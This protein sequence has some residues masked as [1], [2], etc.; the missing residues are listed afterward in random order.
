M[1]IL[2]TGA[3]GFI[4]TELMKYFESR[5]HEIFG[6]SRT[7]NKNKIKKMELN[8]KI[9]LDNYFKK[10]KF[11]IVI[12]LSSTLKNDN[13]I[14]IF[15]ENSIPLITLLECCRLNKIK[16][17]I[18]AS[19]HMV[20]GNTNYV[21]IDENHPKNPKMNYGMMK[22]INENICK[23]YS[24]NYEL[25]T[26]IL[27]ITS[28]YGKGQS[29]NLLIP[30]LMRNCLDKN[31]MIIHEYTNGFQLMDL[32]HVNDVCRAIDLACNSKIKFDIFNI[33]T[34]NNVTALN[35]AKIFLKIND[36]Y[37]IK[38]KKINRNTNHFVYDISKARKKLSFKA[39]IQ[40]SEKII[41]P[42]YNE[43]KVSKS[44]NYV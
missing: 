37:K 3:A 29:D 26:I 15:Q 42:W 44:I 41:K 16:K 43:L 10:N 34:G 6:I 25:N 35:I 33:A 5:K 38:I 7:I 20:Y 13:P 36:K 22:L 17:F 28:V 24:T 23:M 19:S 39:K 1:K 4:G 11:D 9:K 27:R 31:E 2:I 12:H 30:V 18:F 40:P 21:P 32:I 8:D 14:H